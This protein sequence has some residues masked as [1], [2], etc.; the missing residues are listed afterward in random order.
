MKII[1]NKL[2]SL[3]A[4]TFVAMFFST[5]MN[6]QNNAQNKNQQANKVQRFVDLDVNKDGSISKTEFQF[7]AFDKF[8]TDQNGV[9]SRNEYREVNRSNANCQ[10]NGSNKANGQNKN[11]S[12]NQGKM[13]GKGSGTCPNGG[14]NFAKMKNCKPR[15][16]GKS[17]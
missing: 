5:G 10:G 14:K 13:Q 15:K 17:L 6:S 8:D 1:E 4:A 2:G 3:L 12:A 7:E 11:K 9:L 16:L